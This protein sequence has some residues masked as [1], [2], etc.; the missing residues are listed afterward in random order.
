MNVVN[1]SY[2]AT[3]VSNYERRADSLSEEELVAKAAVLGIHFAFLKTNDRTY[4]QI[5]RNGT[6][7]GAWRTTRRAAI[8]ALILLGQLEWDT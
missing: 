8:A 5:L 6:A 7:E 4:T 1:Y 2:L 3:Q